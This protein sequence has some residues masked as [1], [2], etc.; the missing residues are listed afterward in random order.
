MLAVMIVVWFI[1]EQTTLGRRFYAI[2]GNPEASFL[3]GIPVRRLRFVGLRLFRI[4]RSVGRHRL[5]QPAL[6][7]PPHRR[8]TVDAQ[9]D[10]RRLSGHD[11]VSRRRAHVPG[12]LFG[13][14]ILGVL[15]N[16]LNILQVNSYIQNVLTGV[17]IVLAVLV[18]GLA[19]R[20]V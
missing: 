17:I 13:V 14:L 8:R 3:A 5:N 2:G 20:K 9:L 6:L 1:L 11:D 4:G 16:G 10:R 15:S 18:S 12:T 19:R 7:C